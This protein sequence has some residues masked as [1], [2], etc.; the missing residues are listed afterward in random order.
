MLVDDP[1]LSTGFLIWI[2]WIMGLGI[3]ILESIRY[4]LPILI[5]LVLFVLDLWAT[6][7]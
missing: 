3:G 4:G 7:N 5:I 6:S 2:V 1:G